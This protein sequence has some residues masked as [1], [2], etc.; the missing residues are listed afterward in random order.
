M[1]I[2]G[3]G[4]SGLTWH[5]IVHQ[6]RPD[7][8]GGQIKFVQSSGSDQLAHKTGAGQRS[9]ESLKNKRLYLHELTDALV[10]IGRAKKCRVYYN[11]IQRYEGLSLNNPLEIHLDLVDPSKPN[12][13]QLRILLSS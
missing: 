1:K 11:T 4:G 12:L 13:T 6:S 10:L 8:N 5:L 3:S 2:P 9:F 7:Q